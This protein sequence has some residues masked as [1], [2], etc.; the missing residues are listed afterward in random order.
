M[1]GKSKIYYSPGLRGFFSPDVHGTIVEDAVIVSATRHAELIAGQADGHEIVPDRRGRPQLR[2]LG[3]STIAEARAACVHAIKVEAAR[4]I[5]KRM[6]LWRQINAL[7]DQ[8]DPGFHEIDAIRAAS[9]LIETQVAEMADLK[10]LLAFDVGACP[11]WPEFTD[12]VQ[13][14]A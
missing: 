9:N 12:G 6:P 5:D 13:D 1:S 14:N 7:R 11:L 8:S 3:P 2:R 4:Q 10:A